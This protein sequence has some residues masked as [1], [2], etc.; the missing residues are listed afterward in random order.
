MVYF[1]IDPIFQNCLRKLPKIGLLFE[2]Y[3]SL[4]QV[5]GLAA[6]SLI[7]VKLTEME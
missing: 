1:R 3:A 4:M 7:F 6:S 2:L 5:W